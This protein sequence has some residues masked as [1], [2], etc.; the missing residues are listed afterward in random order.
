MIRILRGLARV[1]FILVV[2]G[3]I[4][5]GAVIALIAGAAMMLSAAGAPGILILVLALFA[6]GAGAYAILLL[7]RSLVRF[8]RL[9]PRTGAEA[10]VGHVGVLRSPP[11]P[12]VRVFVDGAIWRA[13]PDL[14]HEEA[15]LHE[16]DRVVVERVHGLT[17]CVRK[18][19]DWELVR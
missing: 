19:E 6:L 3:V 14:H 4:G 10:L 16:G 9:R 7:G 17:L 5:G 18:A 11:A 13:E 15:E 12:E 1:V 2:V 8:R